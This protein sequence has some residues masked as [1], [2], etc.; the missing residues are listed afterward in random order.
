MSGAPAVDLAAR[1]LK[2]LAKRSNPSATLTQIS[3]ALDASK[4]TCLR[5]L[6]SLQEHD[7]VRMDA[8]TRRYSLGVYNV[9]LGARAEHEF[10]YLSLVRVVLAE[11]AEGTRLTAAYAERIGDR[12]VYL[13]KQDPLH[14]HSVSVF[15]G[16]R[17]PLSE[18]SLG[19]WPAVY[20]ARAERA[21]LLVG[22]LESLD[23]ESLAEIAREGVYASHGEYMAGISITSSPVLSAEGSLIG[24]IAAVNTVPSLTDLTSGEIERIVRDAAQRASPN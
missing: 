15:V 21:R 13:A 3:T 1:I 19:V 11:V 2:L 4:S 10:D 23:D 5:V 14:F 24:V 20:A 17:F 8:E 16:N 18:V 7:L 22:H 12:M 6:R 9:V